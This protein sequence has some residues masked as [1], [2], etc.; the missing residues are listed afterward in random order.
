MEIQ[1]HGIS[2]D[3]SV[4]VQR[5]DENILYTNR[6]NIYEGSTAVVEHKDKDQAAG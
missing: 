1:F 2:P 4:V 5:P 6:M 3:V